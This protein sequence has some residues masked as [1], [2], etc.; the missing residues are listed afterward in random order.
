MMDKRLFLAFSLS[1]LVVVATPFLFPRAKV[2][3]APAAAVTGDSQRPAAT[4]SAPTAAVVPAATPGA[5]QAAGGPGAPPAGILG[6]SAA[7]TAGVPLIAAETLAVNTKVS[8]THF[9][10]RGAVPILVELP[11]FKSLG[12]NTG[13]VSIYQK[14]EPLLRYRVLA[15]NDT[16]DLS[17]LTF[18]T[19]R[20]TRASGEQEVTFHATSGATDVTLQYAIQDTTYLGTVKATVR[21][22]AAPAFLLVDLPTGFVSQEGDTMGDITALAYA[23][24]PQK[25]GAKGIAFTKLDPGEQRLEAGPMF[26]ATAKN[27]YFIVGMLTS[28]KAPTIAE[29]HFEGGTRTSKMATRGKATAVLPLAAD[30]STTFDLY[31]G[32]QNW[33]RMRALGRDFENANPYG[34]FM[35]GIVQPF[36]TIVMRALLWMKRTTQLNY[37]WVL[38]IFGVAIRLMMWPLN[39]KAMRASMKLQ[40]LQP[41]LQA[42]QA[43]YKSD[44]QKQQ[45]EI[46]K[47]YSE[48]GMSPLSPL[49]GCLPMLLPMPIL[50][51]L[52]FVFQN[53]IEFRGVA[54]MW[55]PDISLKDPFYVL[56]LLMGASM[57]VLSWIGLRNAPPNPQAK[58]MAYLMPAM[59]TFFLINFA[60]GLNLYYTVQN[61]AALPQ[62]WLIANER[63]KKT[64]G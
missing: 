47:L 51:A 45:A 55:L 2:P 50:F 41:E 39:Q 13:V 16:L 30:G 27:K 5:A 60:S 20:A 35:Q 38:I 28:E 3:P 40:V 14:S 42:V 18:S 43:K 61:L 17:K 36:A 37:G 34:G 25:G 11:G 24:K 12:A 7:P 23:V 53:T 21:G 59:M 63:L 26:W 31:T 52:F 46:M 62:Q 44:P 58:M 56:P 8:H 33:E 48:H 22:I 4:A 15:G 32:P 64:K 57:Y 54:F 6:A 19:I 49:L 10:T 29:V 1:G 9:S